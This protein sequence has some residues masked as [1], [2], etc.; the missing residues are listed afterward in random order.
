[1]IVLKFECFENKIKREKE[2]QG[3]GKEIT[4]VL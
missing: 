3:A 1:M 2:N 4:K